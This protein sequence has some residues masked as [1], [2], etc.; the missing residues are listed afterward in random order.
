[1]E[2]E[3]TAQ[4]ANFRTMAKDVGDVGVRLKEYIPEPHH[5]RALAAGRGTRSA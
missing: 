2:Y 3:E 4:A 5:P 1:M